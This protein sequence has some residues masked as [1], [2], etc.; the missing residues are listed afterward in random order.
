MVVEVA[1]LVLSGTC[2]PVSVGVHVCACLCVYGKC[3]GEM[4]QRIYQI[5]QRVRDLKVKNL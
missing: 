4:M 3:P 1:R 2:V 5:V